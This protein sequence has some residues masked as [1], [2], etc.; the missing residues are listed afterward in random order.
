MVAVTVIIF[1]ASN[2][3]WQGK[4]AFCYHRLLFVA[5]LLSKD[6]VKFLELNLEFS[7]NFLFLVLGFRKP[8]A[9]VYFLKKV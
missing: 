9:L 5:T 6:Q 2:P 8:I 7:N 3:W 4:E 1:W